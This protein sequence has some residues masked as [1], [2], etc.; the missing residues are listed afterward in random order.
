LRFWFLGI[1]LPVLCSIPSNQRPTFPKSFLFPLPLFLKRDLFPLRLG[2]SRRRG[3][4][5][6]TSSLSLDPASLSPS[7]SLAPPPPLTFIASPPHTQIFFPFTGPDQRGL[8]FPSSFPCTPRWKLDEPRF[9]YRD[10]QRVPG[11][12]R[13]PNPP[14]REPFLGL[15]F[16]LDV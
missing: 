2:F 6:L 16:D 1:Y 3:M 11:F 14:P 10:P 12:R 15:L 5:T 8:R 4:E 9:L 7:I 13:V